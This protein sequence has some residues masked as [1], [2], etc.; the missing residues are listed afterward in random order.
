MKVVFDLD[1]KL[2]VTEAQELI[3]QESLP[4]LTAAIPI[5]LRT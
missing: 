3:G 4:L 5:T 2:I 1:D